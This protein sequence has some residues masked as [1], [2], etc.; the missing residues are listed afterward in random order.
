MIGRDDINPNNELYNIT[1]HKVKHCRRDG[2][3]RRPFGYGSVPDVPK[4]MCYEGEILLVKLIPSLLIRN[5]LP[6][7]PLSSLTHH[8]IMLQKG[9]VSTHGPFNDLTLYFEQDI[10]VH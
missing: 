8:L 9:L 4:G 3:Q 5:P 6:P 2:L 7:R 10:F 1:L